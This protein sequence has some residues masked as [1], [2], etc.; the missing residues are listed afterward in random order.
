[1]KILTHQAMKKFGRTWVTMTERN[2]ERHRN[3]LRAAVRAN[4]RKLAAKGW[5]IVLERSRFDQTLGHK[6]P[7]KYQW[8]PHSTTLFTF[9][10]PAGNKLPKNFKL[11]GWDKTHGCEPLDAFFDRDDIKNAARQRKWY[12]KQKAAR[13]S[14]KTTPGT[15][16]VLAICKDFSD[17]ARARDENRP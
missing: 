13:E 16:E 7:T 9:V 15:K 3:L 10:R 6:T 12:A 11:E 14:L 2:V 5:V 8:V 17:W 1:M 4:L